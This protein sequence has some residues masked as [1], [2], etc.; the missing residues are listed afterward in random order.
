[1]NERVELESLG[2]GCGDFG[3]LVDRVVDQVNL[4]NIVIYDAVQ[5]L[6]SSIVMRELIECD[7]VCDDGETVSE[8][9]NKY[10]SSLSIHTPPSRR[11]MELVDNKTRELAEDAANSFN[12]KGVSDV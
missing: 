2:Y 11:F 6:D 8:K 3:G 12:F 9:V 10:L 5:Q 1:M 7:K 4:G